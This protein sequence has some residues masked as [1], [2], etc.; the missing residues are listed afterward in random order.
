ML[1]GERR[2]ETA[3]AGGGQLEKVKGGMKLSGRWGWSSGIAH[4]DGLMVIAKEGD[5]PLFTHFCLLLP[6]EYTIEKTWDSVSMH[7]TGSH[8]LSIKDQFIPEERLVERDVFLEPNPPGSEIHESYIYGMRPAP[9]QKS[10]FIG[11]LLGT[12][13]GALK[14]TVK[15]TKKRVGQ[16]MGERIAT[17]LPVQINLG[18]AFSEIDTAQLVF[19]EYLSKL[20]NIGSSGKDVTADDVLWGKRNVTF[21]SRLCLSATDRLSSGLGASGQMASNPVQRL[22]SDCRG[23]T[24][25]IELNL[26]HALAPTGLRALDLPTGDP[27]IDGKLAEEGAEISLL[28]TQ[29]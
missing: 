16:I 21:A 5:V 23:I 20:H 15:I 28:G 1:R 7:A 27:L 8:H 12:A 9:L 26:N 10:Y 13:K 18:H 24:S 2:R 3:S 22:H 29:I 19:E 14:E 6:G 25:H 17:Q 4:A 11:P